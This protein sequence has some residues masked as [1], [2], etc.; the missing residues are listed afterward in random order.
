VDVALTDL[1]IVP[2]IAHRRA[3]VAASAGLVEKQR[4]VLRLKLAQ[5]GLRR[6]GDG[7]ARNFL[8][9]RRHRRPA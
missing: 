2:R 5:H 4:A 3:A 7:D 1:E 8:L 9:D 6:F